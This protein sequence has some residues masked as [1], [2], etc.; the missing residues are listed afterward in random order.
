LIPARSQ[1]IDS[2]VVDI[3]DQELTSYFDKEPQSVYSISTSSVGVGSES[4]SNRTPLG[5]HKIKHK[6]GNGLP[7]GS[8]L[9]GR[10]ATGEIAEI[11]TQPM[12]STDD[13]VTSRIMWLTG[14][15]EGVNKG[16][17]I[18]SFERYIYIHGTHEEGLIGTP[19]SHGCVRMTNKEVIELFSIVPIGTSVY[20]KP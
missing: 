3:S 2:I 15:E 4:G 14:M 5:W 8:I 20:I 16:P 18:D 10:V 1:T 13:Y 7:A 11:I 6:Y 12:A 19:A 9:R 17:G